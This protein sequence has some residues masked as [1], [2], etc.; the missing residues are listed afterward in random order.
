M[1]KFMLVVGLLLGLTALTACSTPA[2][3]TTSAG[4]STLPT[5][6]TTSAQAQAAAD[7][8]AAHPLA[9]GQTWGNDSQ[10]KV[11]LGAPAPYTPSGS[12]FIPGGSAARAIALDVTIAVP[13]SLGK[14]FPAMLL[15]TQATA[16]SA[17]AQ[18]IEDVG[19]N[20]GRPSANVLPGKSLTWRIAFAVPA[21]PSDFTCTVS[22]AI[23]GQDVYFTGKI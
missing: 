22:T 6:T 23:G 5:G 13:A 10:I 9:F 12:A 11:T 15:T 16:G 18:S 4:S 14:A 19:N 17:Q 2:T 21:G 20:V 3:S 7:G 1:T 8:S